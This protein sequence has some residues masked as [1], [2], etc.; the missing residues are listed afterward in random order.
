[1][2]NDVNIVIKSH[3]IVIRKSDVQHIEVFLTYPLYGNNGKGGGLF[4]LDWDEF[5]YYR[6]VTKD[7]ME[8]Y[9]SCLLLDGELYL[10]D[11]PV[12]R[13][14]KYFPLIPRSAKST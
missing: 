4:L 14:K 11:I 6:I 1:M 10:K 12:Q 5:Y 7:G 2:Y 9:I 13:I 8:L 3:G